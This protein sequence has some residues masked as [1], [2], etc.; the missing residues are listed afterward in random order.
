[1]GLSILSAIIARVTRSIAVNPIDR[2]RILASGGGNYTN[3]LKYDRCTGKRAPLIQWNQA[4]NSHN[5][6]SRGWEE[7]GK[8]QQSN[9]KKI[10]DIF[11]SLPAVVGHFRWIIV[12]IIIVCVIIY[13]FTMARKKTAKSL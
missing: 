5:T 7:I 1:M 11:A 10:V 13:E 9:T 8:A 6:E 3:S 4:Q 2:H 12:T